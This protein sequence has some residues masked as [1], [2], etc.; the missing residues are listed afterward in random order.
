MSEWVGGGGGGGGFSV[1]RGRYLCILGLFLIV[2]KSPGLA[3]K[4]RLSMASPADLAFP[5]FTGC[6]GLTKF[7]DDL[8][9]KAKKSTQ[10]TLH[11]PSSP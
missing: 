1:E 7:L 9:T 8:L 11:P 2:A 3:G 5:G 4:S 10:L 6:L